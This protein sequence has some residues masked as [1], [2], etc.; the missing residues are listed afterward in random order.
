MMVDKVEAPDPTTVVFRLKFATTAFLPA[1]ADPYNWI[2]KKEI[3]DKDPR[4]YEKNILG[5]GPFKF[6][7][8]RD[9]PVDQG[10]KKPRLLPQGAALSRRVY[11]DFCR[12]AG[13]SGRRD[14]A[15]TAPAIEFRGFPPAVRDELVGALGDKITVQESDWNCGTIIE[16]N[17]KK[18]PFDDVRGY[19]AH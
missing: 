7:E 11:R 12:Q 13:G 19:G 1:L 5:S 16:P 6:A 10:G 17:H 9:R 18:K 8:Y 14:R 2:Y 4:W 15:A 3:L